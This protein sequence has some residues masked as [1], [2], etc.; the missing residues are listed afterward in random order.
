MDSAL[1][2]VQKRKE[3]N[4]Q[5]KG[6][7]ACC[8]WKGVQGTTLQFRGEF[9]N[10]IDLG[11]IN[12]GLACFSINIGS[13][14]W[15]SEFVIALWAQPGLSGANASLPLHAVTPRQPRTR[16]ISFNVGVDDMPSFIYMNDCT[17][18]LQENKLICMPVS[19]Y[20]FYTLPAR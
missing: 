10:E 12:D 8:T 4:K 1:K 17:I 3:K 20:S 6:G 7:T 2:I 18:S 11:Y 16:P 5:Q 13:M 15:A 9:H 14:L 19:S